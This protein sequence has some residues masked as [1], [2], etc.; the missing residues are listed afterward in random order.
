MAD[1]RLLGPGLDLDWL[2]TAMARP[3]RIVSGIPDHIIMRSD[4]RL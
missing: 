1:D 4:L 2:T 3:A